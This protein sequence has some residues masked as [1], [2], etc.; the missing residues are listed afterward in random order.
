MKKDLKQVRE[1][2]KE[3]L[4]QVKKDNISLTKAN[5]ITYICS[6]ITRA[7]I[8]EILLN[9]KECTEK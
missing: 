6:N 2:L 5:T 9:K 3:T 1:T 8:A 4:K 7:V